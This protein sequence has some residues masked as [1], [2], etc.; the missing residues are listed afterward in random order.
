MT[1]EPVPPAS[2]ID[3]LTRPLFG[4][5]AT[6]RPDG[7]PQSSVMWFEWNGTRLRFTHTSRR[8]KF[9]NLATEPRVAMSV[10]DPDNPYRF[11]E[12]R[13]T[14]ES[15]EPDLDAQ[16]YRSLQRRYGM[17]Y[18]ITDADAR[19]VL[20]IAPERFIRVEGGEIRGQ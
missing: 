16:F 14:V 10:T 20:A 2:H 11:L 4:H 9:T 6:V 1:P 5:L 7:S 19:V 12:V 13:G 8:Q 17:D 18:D 15:V 3:L